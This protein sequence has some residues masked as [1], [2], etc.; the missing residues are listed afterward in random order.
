MKF[1][2]LYRGKVSS[3]EVPEGSQVG[4]LKELLRRRFSLQD[5]EQ[6]G[7]KKLALSFNTTCLQDDWVLSDVGIPSGSTLHFFLTEEK[8]PSLRIICI[9]SGETVNLYEALDGNTHVSQLKRL[10]MNRTGVPYSVFR[11]SFEGN[12]L[13]E[14]HSLGHYGISPGS[15]VNM[16]TWDGWNNFLNAA[17]RGYAKQVADNLMQDDIEVTEYQRR[18]ALFMAAHFG[19]TDLAARM[20]RMG[21]HADEP[22]GEH[23]A[24]RWCADQNNFVL[25]TTPVHEAAVNGHLPV[26][27]L[28]VRN[29]SAC[30]AAMDG[31]GLTPLSLA[32]AYKRADCV[33]YLKQQR[34]RKGKSNEQGMG[35]GRISRPLKIGCSYCDVTR[36]TC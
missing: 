7:D 31:N 13:F 1:F 15:S 12:E 34:W 35:L 32:I 2:V 30:V 33:S 36:V 14:C 8:S 25:Y 5:V 18:V 17:R 20:L 16:E 19:Y 11:L 29:S 28:F 26:L 3:A 23:P 21:V 24:R 6:S 10:V 4:V 27:R 22:V 9:F